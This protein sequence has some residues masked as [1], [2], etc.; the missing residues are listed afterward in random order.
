MDNSEDWAGLEAFADLGLQ[1][2]GDAGN[3]RQV[4]SACI[5]PLVAT[6]EFLEWTDTNYLRHIKFVELRTDKAPRAVT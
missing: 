2:W 1:A 6:F 4:S 3:A 5:E